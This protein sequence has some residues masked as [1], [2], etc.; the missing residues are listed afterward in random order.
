VKTFLVV[1]FIFSLFGA[2]VRAVKV[3]SV[4]YPRMETFSL[5][6]DCMRV[7]ESTVIAAWAAYL[8]WG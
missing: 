8:L 1:F 2:I 3:M 7:L 4:S 6:E 5:G